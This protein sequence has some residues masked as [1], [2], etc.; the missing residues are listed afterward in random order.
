[1]KQIT[2]TLFLAV[3]AV[4]LQVYA[5]LPGVSTAI[6]EAIELAS[7]RS[8]RVLPDKSSREAAERTL[9]AGI[10][11]H[12]QSVAQAT[13]DGGLELLEASARYGDDV[14]RVAVQA[15]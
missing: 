2:L 11:R 15:S 1:M 8:G 12:G 14:M 6:S 9:E 5:A 7:K 3:A 10:A 4:V 13:A